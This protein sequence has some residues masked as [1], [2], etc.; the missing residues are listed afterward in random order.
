LQASLDLEPD[1]TYF[2]NLAI[3]YYYLGRYD[4]SV[5]IYQRAV[6][7][8][9]NQSFVWLN[10]GD[11]LFFSNEPEKAEAAFRRCAEIAAELLHVDPGR[12]EIMYELA[13]A[14]AMLGDMGN[15]RQL[16]DRSMSIDPDDP[17][18]HY[19]DALVSV[20]EGRY[21]RAIAAL[22]E[23]VAGGNPAIMLAN[24]PHL[25]ALRDI[26]EFIHLISPSD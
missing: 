3:I 7:E 19:F 8:S 17:Y 18:V 14:K 20:K 6:E 9:P 24:E 2:S 23:S 13:W 1:R 15:A 22:Q 26:P 10:Y 21:D 11:A 25:S 4:E 16:I 12:A 5:S